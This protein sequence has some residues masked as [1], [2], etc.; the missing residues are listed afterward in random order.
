MVSVPPAV[1]PARLPESLFRACGY[2]LPRLMFLHSRYA[3]RVGW[4]DIAR[5]LDGFPDDDPDLGSAAFWEEW[6]IRWTAHGD[7]YADLAESSSTAAGRSRAARVAAGCYHWAEF[8]YFDDAE[9]KHSLR[10]RIRT[11]FLR[12]LEGEE[13]ELEEGWLTVPDAGYASVP[14]WLILPPAHRRGPGR[15]PCVVLSNGLDSMTEVE[16]LAVAETYLDRGIAA[17][18][19]DGPGQGV[20]LGRTPLLIEMERVVE[21]LVERL[22]Q[23]PRIAADRLAFFGISFGGYFALRVARFLG[24]RFRCVVNASGG[25]YI[26]PYEGL[27]RRL[28]D[29]FR[30]AFGDRAAPEMQARFDALALDPGRPVRTEVLSIHGALDDIFPLAGLTDLDRAWGPRHRLRTYADEAHV[31]LNVIDAWSLEAADWV[32][33]RLR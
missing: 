19:F 13:L 3:P 11:L 26:A 8:M 28:K 24:A 31:C 14:Y 25:P 32:A 1:R 6:R 23:D 4:G 9:R 27:P 21:A 2:F 18:L 20:Q 12:S 15:L 29:D 17:V 30:F 33:E 7:T 22:R 5:A 16:V 10:R